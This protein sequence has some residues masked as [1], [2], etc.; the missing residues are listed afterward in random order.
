MN[1]IFRNSKLPATQSI[2]NRGDHAV[3]I[4]KHL[5]VLESNDPVSLRFK[6]TGAHKIVIPLFKVLTSIQL[7]DQL[8]L[9]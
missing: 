9:Y 5:I 6:I 8:F 2:F 1:V 4:A 3:D 7:D